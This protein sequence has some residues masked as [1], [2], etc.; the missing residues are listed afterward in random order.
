MLHEP[1]DD[2]GAQIDLD[3]TAEMLPLDVAAYEA[4]MA[5]KAVN[6]PKLRAK[7]GARRASKSA[8]GARDPDNQPDDVRGAST[9]TDASHAA[10]YSAPRI[11]ECGRAWIERGAESLATDGRTAALSA[12][13]GQ[14]WAGLLSTARRLDAYGAELECTRRLLVMSMR[15]QLEAR[16]ERAVLHRALDELTSHVTTLELELA[17]VRVRLEEAK[18]AR[19]LGGLGVRDGVTHLAR[20]VRHAFGNW[21]GVR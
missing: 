4:A 15:A 7:P 6:Q 10:P 20:A 14:T 8:G 2:G 11:D 13:L 19:A 1:D 21:V 12:E 18:R 17:S 16:H 5:A 9:P 3:S